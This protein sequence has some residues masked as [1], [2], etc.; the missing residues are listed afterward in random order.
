MTSI[1]K[2]L[3]VWAFLAI[4][5]TLPGEVLGHGGGLDAYG[6]HR[7]TKAGTYHFHRGPLSGQSFS[8]RAAGHAAYQAHISKKEATSVVA[9]GKPSSEKDLQALINLLIKKEVISREEL[10]VELHK[11]QR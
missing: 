4:L 1:L 8:S 2:R 10:A 6:G 3:S 9:Q 11:L 5:I 7:N